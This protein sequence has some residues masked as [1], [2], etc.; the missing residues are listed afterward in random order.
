MAANYLKAQFAVP[1]HLVP[2]Y[3]D[4][5]DVSRTRIMKRRWP[6]VI[7]VTNTTQSINKTISRLS[8]LPNI[9]NH[10]FD[11]KIS[12]YDMPKLDKFDKIPEKYK[13]VPFYNMDSRG[14]ESK[15]NRRKYNFVGSRSH[16][17][18][19]PQKP[20]FLSSLLNPFQVSFLSN[21]MSQ[22]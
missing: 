1:H 5:S 12:P 22:G 6:T 2:S 20:G 11:P 9:E 4:I 19:L 14:S 10:R 16:E 21:S 3:T 17:P 18:K 15:Q 7:I 13:N 8:N